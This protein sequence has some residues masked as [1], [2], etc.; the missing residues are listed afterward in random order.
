[1]SMIDIIGLNRRAAEHQ[2]RVR[3]D[4]EV[5][6]LGYLFLPKSWRHRYAAEA[7]ATALG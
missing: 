6:E 2:S 4:P 5:A 7:C 1:M 3:A